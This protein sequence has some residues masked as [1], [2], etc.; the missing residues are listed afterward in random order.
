MSFIYYFS[1]MGSTPCSTFLILILFSFFLS[2]CSFAS[3][4]SYLSFTPH[5]FFIPSPSP[6]PFKF[7]YTCHLRRLHTTLLLHITRLTDRPASLPLLHLFAI[8]CVTQQTARLYSPHTHFTRPNPSSSSYCTLLCSRSL[9]PYTISTLHC[10]TLQEQSS[11]SPE[12]KG[13]SAH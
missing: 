11:I 5:P 4:P 8:P 3:V 10:T 12:N 1:P 6:H 7:T 13:I 2:Y 9:S